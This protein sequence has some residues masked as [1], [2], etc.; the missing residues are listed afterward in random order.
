MKGFVK[1]SIICT[2]LLSSLVFSREKEQMKAN[3]DPTITQD[4]K[5][6]LI[7]HSNDNENSQNN[8]EEIILWE[9]DFENGE[10]GWSTGSGWEITSQSSNSESHS[11]LSP[12]SEANMNNTH[13]LL[14]PVLSLDAIGNGETLNFG[15]WLWDDQPGSSQ[16]DDPS[17]TEDESQY[18]AD[19]YSISVLDL[20]ALAWH[21][22]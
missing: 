13:N 8:R 7:K 3:V 16:V 10:N 11:A 1:L 6:Y 15:F 22:S 21:S 20:A 4:G 14:T 5:E 12:D 9:E 19:Y 17:T 2:L 18:L